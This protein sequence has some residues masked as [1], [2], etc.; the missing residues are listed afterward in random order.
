[1]DRVHKASHLP[2]TEVRHVGIAL[3]AIDP[4]QRHIGILHRST[5]TSE[6]LQ[7]HL[8]WHHELRNDSPKTNSV[9]VDP[10]LPP[11]RAKQVA[12][13]CRKVWRQNG[14]RIPYAFSFPND[15]FDADN[16]AF[17]LGV[18]C[19]G[20]TCA[21]FI[22]AIF[23]AVGL[24]MVDESTW[25]NRD[26]D[27]NWQRSI[28]ELLREHGAPEEHVRAVE[29]EV[30]AIRIRPEDVGGAAAYEPWPVV[31]DVAERVGQQI[32]IMLNSSDSAPS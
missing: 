12:A 18:S 19:I 8:A 26:D 22:L 9:W 25:R 27:E 31:F 3:Q 7:L 2:I 32:V 28:I 24:R 29:R 4:S 23:Q 17:L 5:R 15:C 1:M 14:K 10:A 16:G 20:L 6:I 13:F 11:P 30:G 21:T